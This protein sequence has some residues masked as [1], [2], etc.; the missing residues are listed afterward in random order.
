MDLDRPHPQASKAC[1]QLCRVIV[2]VP[3]LPPVGG[4]ST[5]RCQ[6]GSQRRSPLGKPRTRGIRGRL[7]LPSTASGLAGSC[8]LPT[9]LPLLGPTQMRVR[10]RRGLLHARPGRLRRLGRLAREAR[11]H[12][13]MAE[14]RGRARMR[15]ASASRRPDR[16][17]GPPGQRP[18]QACQGPERAR[19]GHTRPGL[20]SGKDQTH[21]RH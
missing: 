20:R 17:G 2:Q 14:D 11:P 8:S 21:H 9:P 5:L 7:R 1:C 3:P 4:N 12:P 18:L 15:R 16:A 13:E 6:T 19:V 10:R